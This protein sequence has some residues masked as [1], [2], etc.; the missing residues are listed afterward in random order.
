SPHNS[1]VFFAIKLKN[2]N[3]DKGIKYDAVQLNFRIFNDSNTTRPLAN[4]TLQGFYQ[5][6]QKTADKPGNASVGG[7]NVTAAVN[8]KVYYRVD[9]TTKVKYKILVFYTKRHSLW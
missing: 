4:A 6:H 2:P 7:A 5:G 3:K 1:T 9:F 8:D